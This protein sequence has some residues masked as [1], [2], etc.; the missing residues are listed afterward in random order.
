MIAGFFAPWAVTLAILVLHRVIPAREVD[1]YVRD[2]S[3]RPLRYR[4]NG[5]RVFVVVIGLWLLAGSSGWMPFDWAWTHRW[6]T[7]A[8]A[9]TLGLLFTAAIVL[10]A[11]STGRSFVAD[12]FFGRRENPQYGGVDAK[13]LLYL[14][15]AVILEL[16]VLSFASHHR[17]LYPDDPSEGIA[18]YVGMFT[19][20]LAEYL[21][22]EEVHLY[23]YDFFAERVGF[24]LGWGCLTFYP[25]F[26][27]VGLW[28][29]A[30]EPDPHPPAL[31][32][33]A[34][35]LLFFAGW[36]LARGANLQKFLFK[37]RPGVK[38]LGVVPSEVV[39]DGR[40]QLL[41]SGFWGVS[42]H[43]NYLG[44]VLMG[45]ALCLVLGRPGDPWPWLYPLYYVLLLVPRQIDDDRRCAE[46]YGPLWDEYRK[47][48]RW[49]IVPGVY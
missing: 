10:P 22:F 17:A 9:C 23:T 26:Y 7:L 5:L 48:V 12:V 27:C 14:V 38:L 19:F 44:E 45:L 1:G 47:R 30:D 36:S 13:M 31:L 42:R 18:L 28:S 35:V 6:E 21:Y 15:G 16:N 4:L 43:V 24:K 34:C 3:G 29:A 33:A 11:P 25:F 41:V 32:L 46:K 20:F 37:T 39:T 2:A 40:H 8:G 49:R